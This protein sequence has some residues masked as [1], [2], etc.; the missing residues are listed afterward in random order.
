[1]EVFSI[2]NNKTRP[3]ACTNRVLVC[4]FTIP[5][6]LV[7]CMVLGCYIK[8]DMSADNNNRVDSYDNPLSATLGQLMLPEI[9]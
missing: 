5:V 8:M 9:R 1:M 3:S 7:E 6:A 2:I 4:H